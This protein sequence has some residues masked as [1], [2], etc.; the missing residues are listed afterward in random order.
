MNQFKN[1]KFLKIKKMLVYQGSP[2]ANTDGNSVVFMYVIPT[3][4]QDKHFATQKC[5]GRQKRQMFMLIQM[6]TTQSK[7]VL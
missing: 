7:S 3:F 6:H 2:A 5:C 1:R 4:M